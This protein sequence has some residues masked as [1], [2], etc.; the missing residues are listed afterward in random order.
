MALLMRNERGS[1][2]ILAIMAMLIMGIL[3]IS[4]ALLADIESRVGV[5]YKQQGQAEALA[6]AGLERARDLIRAA[7]TE[8]SFTPWL[9]GPIATHL[10][11]SGA[12]LPT[13]T[14]SAR[15]DND[16]SAFVPGYP[17]GISEGAT[18]SPPQ[19]CDNST[20][21][22]QV[23]ILTSWGEAG[24]A[25]SRVRAVVGVDNPWKHVCSNAKPDN[26]GYCNEPGN[27]NGNPTVNPADPND[28]N[29]P[30]AYNF[31]PLPMLG[32]SRIAPLLHR[33]SNGPNA[34]PAAT[35]AALCQNPGPP[36]GLYAGMYAYPYPSG[37]GV[38]RFVMMGEDPAVVPTA[39]TC[40][41][42]PNVPAPGFNH[43]YFGY[44][45]CALSTYCDPAEGHTCEG[46]V[47]RRGCLHPGD[48]RVTRDHGNQVN[49][50][51]GFGRWV[52]FDDGNAVAYP[53]FSGPNNSYPGTCHQPKA[54]LDPLGNHPPDKDNDHGMVYWDTS[55]AAF[56]AARPW[57]SIASPDGTVNFGSQIGS[58]S[59]EFQVYVLNAKA[60]FGNNL[61]FY[62]TF[63]V[64]GNEDTNCSDKDFQIGGGATSELWA[65]PN[66]TPAGAGWVV[67]PAPP[68]PQRPNLGWQYGYPLAALIYNPDL[69]APTVIPT[70]APQGTCAD[71]GSSNSQIHGMVFSGGHVEFN[72]LTFDGTVVAFEIQTQG[73]AV[74]NYNTTYGNFTPPPGFPFGSGNQVVVIR[75]SFMVCVNYHDDTGA[76]T[77]CN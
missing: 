45:D 1:A 17:A 44:F 21:N 54:V 11:V 36:L 52:A 66:S 15:L 41:D 20:D 50:N 18:Q 22:N 25:R 53:G 39:R 26:N 38:P 5:G 4:F 72:P 48:S 34:M 60:R 42:E 19:A 35:Q 9:S 61:A 49:L 71:L 10:L 76:A 8:G 23:A 24:N 64:E 73:A 43:R 65:G 74:Y 67:P 33:A 14:Y 31:L 57:I 75:K 69:A 59:R 32:C 58:M 55:G 13:G 70:Y 27:R 51:P 77:N 16:C 3:S 68:A 47:K 29:G 7:P 28:P 12:A 6:E 46:G 56:N 40:N 2:L 37:A 62:G 30:S 63:A